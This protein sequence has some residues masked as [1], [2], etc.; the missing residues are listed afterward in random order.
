MTGH[1]QQKR[2]LDDVAM[3][4]TAVV[5]G[6]ADAAPAKRFIEMGFIPGTPVTAVRT[7]PLG[8][9]VEFAVLGSRVAIRAVDAA[10]IF[11]GSEQQGGSG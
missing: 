2:T 9:P 6:F 11:V 10:Q 3:G 5:A 1:A 7:A 8:D 4:A